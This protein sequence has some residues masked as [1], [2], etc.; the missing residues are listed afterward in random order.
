MNLSLGDCNMIENDAFIGLPE[1]GCK[2]KI[3]SFFLTF[4]WAIPPSSELKIFIVNKYFTKRL[5]NVQKIFYEGD[6][7]HQN[8][9]KKV[10]IFF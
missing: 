10:F 8:V 5:Y 7:V 9:K 6:I 1:A 3:K 4:R 2:K